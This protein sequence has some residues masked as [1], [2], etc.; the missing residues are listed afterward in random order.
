MQP[1]N[2]GP[3]LGKFEHKISACCR[4]KE[5]SCFYP[6]ILVHVPEVPWYIS[7]CLLNLCW[8]NQMSPTVFDQIHL[9]D[10]YVPLTFLQI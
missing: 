3:I 9:R 7:N 10:F 2:I 4:E 8:D 1:V 6:G 5:Q